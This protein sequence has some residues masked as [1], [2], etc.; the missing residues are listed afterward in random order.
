MPLAYRTPDHR[1]S[2]LPD[3]PFRPHYYT[4]R[5]GLRVHYLDEGPRDQFV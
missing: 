5:E 4:L 1:F 2:N 3:F